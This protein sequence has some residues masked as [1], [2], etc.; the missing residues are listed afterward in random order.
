MGTILLHLSGAESIKTRALG[1]KK[2][3]EHN[4]TSEFIKIKDEIIIME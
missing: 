2:R 1:S 3:R 4:E